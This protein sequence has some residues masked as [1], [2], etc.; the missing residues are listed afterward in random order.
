MAASV[1]GEE[2]MIEALCSSL[3]EDCSISDGICDKGGGVLS[4][5][6]LLLEYIW[7]KVLLAGLPL[8]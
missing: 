3:D 7:I 5:P 2:M 8:D 1:L 4:P 6:A